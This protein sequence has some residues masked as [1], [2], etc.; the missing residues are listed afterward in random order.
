MGAVKM[1]LKSEAIQV[2]MA[3]LQWDEMEAIK[4]MVLG[5]EIPDRIAKVVLT[6]IILFLCKMLGWVEEANP[7]ISK[8]MPGRGNSDHRSVSR[9]KDICDI[10]QDLPITVTKIGPVLKEAP[11]IKASKENSDR[12]KISCVKDI[13]H[14]A[15]SLPLTVTKIEP[16]PDEETL[17]IKCKQDFDEIEGKIVN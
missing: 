1:R 13:S 3:D 5:K 9:A 14:I 12:H 4:F 15:Q 10:E 8:T 11:E 2:L 7:V 16:F 17:E 6:N